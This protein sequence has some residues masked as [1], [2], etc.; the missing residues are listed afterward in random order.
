MMT[1]IDENRPNSGVILN[2]SI[3]LICDIMSSKDIINESLMVRAE[4]DDWPT[5]FQVQH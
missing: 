3:Q 2:A 5:R 1:E 4:I